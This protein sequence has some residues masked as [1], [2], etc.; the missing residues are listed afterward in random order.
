MLACVCV[1]CDL[2]LTMPGGKVYKP[3]DK[4]PG[5]PAKYTFSLPPYLIKEGEIA[6]Q[7]IERLVRD[8]LKANA[9][10]QPVL[11]IVQRKKGLKKSKAATL[12][13]DVDVLVTE[14]LDSVDG[15]TA[16]DIADRVGFTPK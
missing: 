15:D 2:L 16:V 1:V 11:D 4:R 14:L 13:S 5:K 12:D 6:D 10:L 7:C 8:V 9:I 3:K